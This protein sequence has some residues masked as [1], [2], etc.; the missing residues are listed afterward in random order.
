MGGY[1]ENRW[2]D[3]WEGA[4]VGGEHRV[5]GS[6]LIFEVSSSGSEAPLLSKEPL[7]LWL[8]QRGLDRPEELTVGL[9]A[10]QRG[11]GGQGLAPSPSGFPSSLTP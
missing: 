6:T 10:R 9:G 11:T 5:V 3:T 2:G 8:H 1:I 7:F 4:R